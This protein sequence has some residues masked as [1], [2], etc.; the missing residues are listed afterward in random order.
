[1]KN[2][3]K[4]LLF[5]FVSFYLTACTIV[6]AAVD[7]ALLPVAIVGATAGGIADLITDDDDDDDDNDR[8]D[9]DDDDDDDDD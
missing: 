8:D 2:I 9:R 7:V 4:S 3:L 5:V 1:M 6:D